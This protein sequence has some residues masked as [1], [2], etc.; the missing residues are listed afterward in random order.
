MRLTQPFALF[1]VTAILSACNAVDKILDVTDPDIIN[2]ADIQ[3]ASAAEALRIGVLSRLNLATTGNESFLLLGGLLADEYRSGDTFTQRNETDR[4]NVQPNNTNVRD[5]FR[6]AYRVRT[7][8][9]QAIEALTRFEAAPWKIAEMYLALAYTE[10]QLAENACSGIPLSTISGTDIVYDAPRRTDEVLQSAL[11]HVNTA[12]ARAAG[13]TA[14]DVRI[15]HAASVL[16][17]RILLNVGK[18]R[19]AE[20]ATAVV[21][22]PTDYSYTQEHSQT[23]ITNAIWT[24]NNSLGRWIVSN[25]EGGNT[26]NFATA[27]DPRVPV[28]RS[29]ASVTTGAG[30][31]P[32]CPAGTISRA[33]DPGARIIPLFVQQIWPDRG[34]SVGVITGVEARLVEAEAALEAGDPGTFLS[35]HNALR[36]RVPGLAALADPGTPRAREDLHFREKAF[37]LFGRGFRL[38]DMRRL[39]RQY[40]RTPD[41]VFPTG[42]WFKGGT[43]GTQMNFPI[44][45]A[46]ENNPEFPKDQACLDSGA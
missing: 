8:A 13:T 43:F 21:A 46:E 44:P 17:A 25:G 40:Q 35:I 18:S 26:I 36:A 1:A 5:A 11:G 3:S 14:D 28:C 2:P 41:E 9:L 39:V 12:L 16:K 20:A 22:V 45:Q 31:L 4:R 30:N 37:W 10:N 34:S 27:G 15:R 7:S 6:F 32:V 38:G 23:S 42:P 24:L 33:F 19:F 29:S